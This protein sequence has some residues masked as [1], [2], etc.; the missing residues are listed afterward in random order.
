MR[1]WENVNVI[2]EEAGSDP[3]RAHLAP[4]PRGRLRTG[5]GFPTR[6]YVLGGF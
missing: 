5:P 2:V 6:N 3:P 1:V 4:R